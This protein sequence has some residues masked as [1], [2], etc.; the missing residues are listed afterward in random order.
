MIGQEHLEIRLIVVPPTVNLGLVRTMRQELGERL[1]RE[2]QLVAVGEE[3]DAPVRAQLRECAVNF[4][5]WSP[6]DDTELTFILKSALTE[7]NELSRRTEV[8]VPVDITARMRAGTRREV[9]ILSGLS[10]RGAFI[11]LSDPLGVNARIQ[12]EFEL[13]G[14]QF[15][16]FARVVYQER[17]VAD[18]PLSSSGNGVVFYGSDREAELRICKLVEER[19]TRFLP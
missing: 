8:R 6:F 3:P 7:R 9:V 1:G 14:E 13:A 18:R 19:G 11:E 2:P 4:V 5:L 15:R 10:R 17:E 12:L 16:F